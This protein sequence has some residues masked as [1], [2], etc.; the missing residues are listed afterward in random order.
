M[1][2]SVLQ[3]REFCVR[4]VREFTH[5]KQTVTECELAQSRLATENWQVQT[6]ILDRQE[7]KSKAVF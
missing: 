7:H 1:P 2:A 5:I 4:G 3:M 6:L